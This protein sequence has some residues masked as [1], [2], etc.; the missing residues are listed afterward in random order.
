MDASQCVTGLFCANAVCCTSLCDQP[1]MRCDVPPNIGTC[2]SIAAP[3]PTLSPPGLLVALV[4]LLAVA[5]LA[6]WRGTQRAR[7]PDRE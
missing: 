3:A 5:G 7:L 6:L 2:S 1:L 4:L